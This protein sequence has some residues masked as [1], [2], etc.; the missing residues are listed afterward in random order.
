MDKKDIILTIAG[1]YYLM[2]A[3]INMTEN[4]KSAMFYKVIPF[5]IGLACLYIAWVK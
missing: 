1:V 2:F 3:M 5:F 4:W